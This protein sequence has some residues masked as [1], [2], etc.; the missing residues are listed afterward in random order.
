MNILSIILISA[1]IETSFVQFSDA[2][3]SFGITRSRS[4]N[5]S[6][7]V[8][9]GERGHEFDDPPVPPKA[10]APDMKKMSQNTQNAPKGPPPPYPGLGNQPVP[11]HNAPP[12]Y[13]PSYGGPYGG[14]SYHNN[15]S[16][17]ANHPSGL[18]T[19]GSPPGGALP[20]GVMP[21][22]YQQPQRNY[23][24][25]MMTNLFAG[26]AGY[27]LAR[28]F[29]GN[30]HHRDQEVIIIDNRQPSQ[31]NVPAL[32]DGEILLPLNVPDTNPHPHMM[33]SSTEI[34]REPIAPQNGPASNDYNFYQMP[35]YGIPLYG[36][37]MQ[38]QATSYQNTE[39][40]NLPPPQQYQPSQSA[41]SEGS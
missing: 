5:K 1:I 25:G 12:A 14:Q 41:S 7:S 37:N 31:S 8:R 19:F 22:A 33:A 15:P 38:A 40:L 4:K 16:G 23:G 28:A 35:Q 17:F 32:P 2:K 34:P 39:T 9:R 18:N 10:T 36:Y 21:I 3:R 29:S 26:L 20:M 13:N 24:G 11:H 27:Q 6:P 30:G